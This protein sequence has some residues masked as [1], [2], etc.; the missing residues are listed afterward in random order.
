MPSY[1]T[2]I[3]LTQKHIWDG[4]EDTNEL[5]GRSRKVLLSGFQYIGIINPNRLPNRRTAK[6]M[7]MTQEREN[8]GY[9]GN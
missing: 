2:A 7:D 3:G 9:A 6:Y 1:V 4:L 8:G 5:K